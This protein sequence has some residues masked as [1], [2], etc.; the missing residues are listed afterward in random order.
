V[1]K[2]KFILKNVV[3]PKSNTEPSTNQKDVYSKDKLR[4]WSIVVMLFQLLYIVQN[5][6]KDE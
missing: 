4:K 1:I 3:H 6:E 5:G 2:Q